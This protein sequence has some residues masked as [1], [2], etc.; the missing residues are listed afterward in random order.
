MIVLAPAWTPT[1]SLLLLLLLLFSPGLRG[2]SD[3]SFTYNPISS[4]FKITIRKLADYLLQD[5]PV[6]VASNLQDDE[7][8]GALWRLTLAQRWMVRLKTVAGAQMRELLE[9]VNTEIVFVD[10]CPFQP[11]PSCLR[12]VQTNISHLLQDISMQLD[13]LKPRITGP[14][15]SKCLELQCQPDASTILPLKITKALESGKPAPLPNSLFLLLLLV[16]A[17]LALL[18][19]NWCLRSQRL[20]R[21]TIPRPGEPA[22]RDPQEARPLRPPHS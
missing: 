15:F 6:T 18:A 20:S 21:R 8:C 1:T 9:A 5:Y 3:C 4:T 17:A 14:D 2:T 12:L 13:T 11:L 16:P 7:E 10:S 19:I 22:P